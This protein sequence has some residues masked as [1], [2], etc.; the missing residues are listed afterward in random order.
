MSDMPKIKSIVIDTFTAFQK[1]EI[2][3]KWEKGSTSHADWKDYGVDIVMFIEHLNRRGFTCVGVLGYEG[4]GKSFGMKTLPSKTNVWFNAD[5]KNTTF[6]GGKEEYG[7]IVAPTRYMK[8]PRTYSDVISV[9]DSM[10]M[11]NLLDSEPVAFLIAHIE[12]YKAADGIVRQKLK[13]LG[14]L[15][16]KINIEDKL[17]MCYYTDVQAEGQSVKYKLR[18]QNSGSNTCRTM[19]DLHDS[20]YIDNDFNLIMDA[21]KIY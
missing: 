3:E 13:T 11:T 14:K 2:L 6:K 5:N 7:T 4:T 21:L 12:D 8:Q 17:T 15:A 9:V 20:L 10:Q 1:N 19:E 18:T 16:N